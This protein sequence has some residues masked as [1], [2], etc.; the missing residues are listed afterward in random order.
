MCSTLSKGRGH[1]PAEGVLGFGRCRANPTPAI[2]VLGP[3]GS[4]APRGESPARAKA[5]NAGDGALAVAPLGDNK[6][7][8]GL[9]VEVRLPQPKGAGGQ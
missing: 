7:V 2:G 8:R 9:V 4:E 3:V 5:A 6:G 1:E